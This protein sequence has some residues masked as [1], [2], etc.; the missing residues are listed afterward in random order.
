MATRL[1]D[2]NSRFLPGWKTLIEDLPGRF[3]VG[4]DSS[5]TPGNLAAFDRRV[6]K[7]RIALGG[8]TPETARKVATANLH[9]LFRR[10]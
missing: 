5:A 1:V 7:I 6:R 4:V 9:R 2:E 3:I 10:P 8:L